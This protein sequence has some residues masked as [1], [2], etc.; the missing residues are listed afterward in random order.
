MGNLESS[1]QITP[2]LCLQSKNRDANLAPLANAYGEEDTS[3]SLG[4]SRHGWGRKV[5]GN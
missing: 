1:T 2:E 5:R 4:N 3:T